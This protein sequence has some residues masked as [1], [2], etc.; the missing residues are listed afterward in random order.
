MKTFQKLSGVLWANTEVFII[1]ERRCVD[2]VNLV[3][4]YKE[5]AEHHHLANGDTLVIDD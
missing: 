3:P 1:D 5:A 2:C 4:W